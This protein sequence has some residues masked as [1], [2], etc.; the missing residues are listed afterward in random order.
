VLGE[1][2]CTTPEFLSDPLNFCL[3]TCSGGR[4]RNGIGKAMPE[5]AYIIPA[6]QD[7]CSGGEACLLKK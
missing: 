2:A 5:V 6:S 1:M 7:A 3:H 4:K